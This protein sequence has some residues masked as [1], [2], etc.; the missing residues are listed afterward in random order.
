VAARRG[1]KYQPSHPAANGE[2]T[3]SQAWP[4]LIFPMRG[5]LPLKDTFRAGF[6]Q[7]NAQISSSHILS[8]QVAQA[9]VS[10]LKSAGFAQANTY[11]KVTGNE[12]FAQALTYIKRITRAYAQALTDIDQVY[13]KV[14]QATADILQAYNKFAQAQI[15]VLQTYSVSSQAQ[16]TLRVLTLTSQVSQA[17]VDIIPSP[18]RVT[19]Q[20]IEV[21]ISYTDTPTRVT[22][23]SIDTLVS[24]TDPTVRVTNQI[25]QVLWIPSAQKYAQAQVNV[26]I[27]LNQA[28]AQAATVLRGLQ[29]VVAQSGARIKA[30]S[31][32]FSQAQA[33]IFTTSRVFSQA[34][35]QIF[36]PLATIYNQAQAQATIWARSPHFAQALARIHRYDGYAQAKVSIASKKAVAQAKV[37]IIGHSRG[38]AQAGM[39]IINAKAYQSAQS[40][41][42]ISSPI[43]LQG[44]QVQTY[45]RRS[46]AFAQAM[47]IINARFFFAQAMGSIILVKSLKFAQSFTLIVAKNFAFAQANVL[48]LSGISIGQ[49]QALIYTRPRAYAAAQAFVGHF[50]YAYAQAYISSI[51][52]LVKYGSYILPGY[53]QSESFVSS[54]NVQDHQAPY[55]DGSLSAYSGLENKIISMKMR[56]F[57]EGGY[58]FTKTQTQRAATMLRAYSG[59]TKTYIQNPDRYYLTLAKS[60]KIEKDAQTTGKILDYD[61][62]LEAKPWLISDKIYTVSGISLI[63]AT[64]TLDNGTWTPTNIRISGT[65]ITL[66]GYTATEFTGFISVSGAVTNMYITNEPFTAT[67]SNI[68]RI[69]AIKNF[70][71]SLYIGPGTTYVAVT[72]ATLCEITYQDRW[73]L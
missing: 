13:S 11:I 63:T 59:W 22:N 32:V 9:S 27:P 25:I 55:M 48:I 68:D 54:M 45:I 3:A 4:S 58:L 47:A 44:A 64:R 24:Y 1:L 23:Q 10:I 43:H 62:E 53:A 14:S 41:A 6:G 60:I 12:S 69:T 61:F 71:S 18:A 29:Q 5:G 39:R 16:V 26:L 19:S 15:K 30:T 67:I 51:T 2:G 31:R 72:G 42:Q 33:K 70:D 73:E 17:Q 37:Y 21:L 8:S 56:V 46:I 20:T 36:S 65:N 35:T 7:S 34:Q 40:I 66:S 38:F 50:R 57:D 52:Y 49:A 28:Y